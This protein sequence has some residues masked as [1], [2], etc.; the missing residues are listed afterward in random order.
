MVIS[1]RAESTEM[2][3]SVRGHAYGLPRT[4]VIELETQAAG[5][6]LLYSTCSDQD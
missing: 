2:R 6:N 3:E 4:S 1:R 5:L